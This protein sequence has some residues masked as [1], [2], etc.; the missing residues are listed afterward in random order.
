MRKKFRISL[1]MSIFAFVFLASLG[2]INASQER[3]V[4]TKT[5]VKTFTSDLNKYTNTWGNEIALTRIEVPSS[6]YFTHETLGA[7]VSVGWNYTRWH[8][9]NHYQSDLGF[10]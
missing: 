2:T 5:V 6:A 8:K 4:G 7:R 9:T 10:H 3:S 1:S